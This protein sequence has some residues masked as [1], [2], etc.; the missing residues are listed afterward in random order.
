MVVMMMS[1]VMMVM[2]TAAAVMMM[3]MV[4]RLVAHVRLEADFLEVGAPLFAASSDQFLPR[5]TM[6]V[7][8]T[9]DTIL[10]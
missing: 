10:H 5:V 4:G 3:M 8:F 2:M 7:V 1:A 9:G 6:I